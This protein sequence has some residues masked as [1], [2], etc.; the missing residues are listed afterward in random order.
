MAE[1]TTYQCPNC[2]GAM[3]FDGSIGKLRC[4]F[5]ESTFTVEEVE[6]LYAEKQAKADAKVAGDRQSAIAAVEQ[7]A[8][9]L[10]EE[11]QAALTN[12]YDQAMA[13]GKSAEEATELAR[14]AA[15]AVAP[16]VA[17]VSAAEASTAEQLH[18]SPHVQ[19]TGDP[20]QDYISNSKWPTSE[21][22]DL[23][24]FNCPAC[25]AQL[26]VDQVTAVTS[27]PYCG[28]NAVVP[29]QLSDVLKPDYVI[30]FKL[31]KDDAIAALK[32]YY[33]GKKFLPSSFTE[34]NHLEEVQG[35][36]VP[37]WLYTGIA[38]GDVTL[39]ARN[40]RTWSDS[41]N[42]YVETDH[43]KLH[44]SGNMQFVDVPVDGSTKMPD[45]HMDAIEP[46]DYS[47]MV[48]FSVAYLPGFVTDRYDQ[49]VQECDGRAR[50]RV[51]TTCS[52]TLVETATGYMETDVES[53]SARVDWSNISYALLPVWMLHTR[54]DDEDYLFAMNGQTGKLIGDLPIDNRKVILRSAIIFIPLALILAV[55]LFVLFA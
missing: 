10:T 5:C 51:E 21:T 30:P 22:D 9:T 31:G 52:D 34:E 28:N 6:A 3:H 8:G 47:E 17:S 23:R 32:E 20:I 16:A 29:G 24:A 48:P 44:R 46:F 11:M 15:L 39:N 27:C 1:T 26:L 53:A 13:E 40:I 33:N 14:Q 43:Y 7:A 4:E 18:V 25:G 2:S 12:A 19:T 54:W 35:V 50:S 38:E 37:F 49:D 45:A 41:D 42:E 36:Y 55:L